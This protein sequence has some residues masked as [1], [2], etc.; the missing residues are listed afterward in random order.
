MT[1]SGNFFWVATEAA[2][3]A[4][5]ERT[6]PKSISCIEQL[7]F[8]MD[9]VCTIFL[10]KCR[11]TV[12]RAPVIDSAQFFSS[13]KLCFST[14]EKLFFGGSML[15]WIFGKKSRHR[16]IEDALIIEFQIDL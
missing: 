9:P 5:V 4:R 10:T 7:F 8:L 12:F 6:S 2:T 1:F 16:I 14:F 13:E 11:Q 3:G 15:M